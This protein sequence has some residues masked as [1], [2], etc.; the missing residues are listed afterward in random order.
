LGG[1]NGYTNEDMPVFS[2]AS[3]SYCWGVPPLGSTSTI[4]I[5]Y[6]WRLQI[7]FR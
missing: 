3:R 5:A 6:S 4:R 1:N 7:F 2:A